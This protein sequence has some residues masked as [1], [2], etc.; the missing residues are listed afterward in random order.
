MSSAAI[1]IPTPIVEIVQAVEE[2][3][4]QVKS[5]AQER[6]L[7]EVTTAS[8][9]PAAL[10]LPATRAAAFITAAKSAGFSALPLPGMASLDAGMRLEAPGFAPLELRQTPLGMEMLAPA[11]A[12]PTVTAVV[13]RHVTK[14]AVEHLKD[15]GLA[16]EVKTL[17]SGEVR[18][19]A[20]QDRRLPGARITADV[21]K[22]GTMAVDI[23]QAHGPE[24]EKVIEELAR[25]VDGQ[26]KVSR[27]PEF[28]LRR[29]ARQ[30]QRT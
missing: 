11:A 30:K 25:A 23:A 1:V 18:I 24:C 19:E 7:A 10:P 20:S 22:D 12:L 28:H 13:R 6:R 8:L 5:K 2:N 26:A 4:R 21:K 9:V 27:K 16:V 3:K 17:P 29:L 15:Q 14:K